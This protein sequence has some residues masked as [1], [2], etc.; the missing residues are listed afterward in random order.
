MTHFSYPYK[1]C[2]TCPLMYQEIN[3][4]PVSSHHA[5]KF[6]GEMYFSLSLKPFASN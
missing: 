4:K 6:D 1:L 5:F 2:I 3:E